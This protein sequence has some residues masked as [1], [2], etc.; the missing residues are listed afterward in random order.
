[1]NPEQVPTAPLWLDVDTGVDDALAIAF[2][3]RA[4]ANLVGISSVAGNVQI[5]FATDNSRRVLALLGADTVPVHRGAS[6]PLAVA[7]HDAAHVHGTNGLGGANIGERR[8]PESEVNGVQA[9]LDAAERYAGELVLVA[10]GPLTNVAIACILRPLL[11]R[12]VRRLV[13]MSGAFRVPGN[14]TPHAEF[15]AFADPHA[16]AQ[17]MALD[18]TELIAV[19]L[20]VT[21]QTI[22]SRAQWAGIAGDVPDTA[23]LVRQIAARTFIERGMDGFYVHDPLAVAVALDPSLVDLEDMAIE[24]S[25]DEEHRGQTVPRGAGAV[26]VAT[27]VDAARFDRWFAERLGIPVR[28]RSI[29]A[30]RSE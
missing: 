6:R 21:H 2:A 10:L 27:A 19:G 29:A 23:E 16:A 5:D 1:M 9:I 22:V 26:K 20:D 14:V 24:V 12:Q 13:V 30:D 15:N 8:A 28:E 17:V 11:T 7:Y 18:W 4:G 3:V 25:T